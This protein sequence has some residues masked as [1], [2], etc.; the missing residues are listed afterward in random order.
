MVE[1]HGILQKTVCF[2]ANALEAHTVAYVDHD[3]KN[4]VLSCIACHSLGDCFRRDIIIP[5]EQSGILGEVLRQ[6]RLVEH[7]R[8]PS[9]SIHSYVPFYMPNREDLIKALCVIPIDSGRGLLYAD[10]KQKWN[11]GRKEMCLMQN[12]ANLIEKLIENLEYSLNHDKY[13]DMLTCFYETDGLIESAN[14]LKPQTLDAL[15]GKISNFTGADWVFLVSRDLPGGQIQIRSSFPAFSLPYSKK[16]ISGGLVDYVFGRKKLTVISKFNGKRYG[17][18]FLFAPG[19]PIPRE[20]S[21]LGLYGTTAGSEW[22]LALLS[23]TGRLWDSD[24]VYTVDRI[25]RHFLMAVDRFVLQEKCEHLLKYDCFT[26]LLHI[27]AFEEY[28]QSCFSHA[29]GNNYNLTLVVI[30]WEPY[31]KLCSMVMPSELS[32]INHRIVNALQKEVLGERAIIGHLGENRLGILLEQVNSFDI[33]KC[34][35]FLHRL[36]LGKEFGCQ[37]EFYSGMARYPQDSSNVTELWGKAYQS[38]RERIEGR[39]SSTVTAYDEAAIDVLVR[40]DLA[41]L[42]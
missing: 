27:R 23:K 3:K 40:R 16:K 6:N 15:L 38:L 9:K 41:R 35:Y 37:I 19:E 4:G 34:E 14:L 5:V 24:D 20:G 17:N 28:V 42:A 31:L 21:L 7:G 13:V 1:D 26:G 2:L 10:T 39:L 29:V 11:F 30:Q 12:A 18:H 32:L 22:V 25:F 8:L 36:G 33:K